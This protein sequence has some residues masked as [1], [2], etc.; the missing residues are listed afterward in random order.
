MS[1]HLANDFVLGVWADDREAW[2]ATSDGLS[3]ATFIP[4]QEPITHASTK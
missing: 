4:S 3:H 1:T 2:L